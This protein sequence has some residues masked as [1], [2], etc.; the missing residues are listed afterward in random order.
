MLTL[1]VS[2]PL[3]AQIDTTISAPG[4]TSSRNDPGASRLPPA[5]RPEHTASGLPLTHSTDFEDFCG[6]AGIYGC[7]F[8]KPD[9]ES[10][11]LLHAKIAASAELD[12][13][14]Q[15]LAAKASGLDRDLAAL[16]ACSDMNGSSFGASIQAKLDAIK[17]ARQ[18]TEVL[19]A[20]RGKIIA[21]ASHAN[22]L[23]VYNALAAARSDIPKSDL[24]TSA[25]SIDQT[26]GKYYLSERIELEFR[27][28][29]SIEGR[30]KTEGGQYQ[31]DRLLLATDGRIAL[32]LAQRNLDLGL[33][34]Q[35]QTAL[36]LGARLLDVA[37]DFSPMVIA[38]AAPQATLAIGVAMTV[39][40]AKDYYEAR[41]GKRL[42]SGEALAAADRAM[43]MTAVVLD[44]VPLVGPSFR[45][46]A[47]ASDCLEIFTDMM[48]SAKAEGSVSSASAAEVTELSEAV[49]GAERVLESAME[50]GWVPGD[51]KRFAKSAS[52]VTRNGPMNAGRMHDI[53]MGNGTLSYSFRGS[54]YFSYKN[55]D[56]LTL[57]R[58]QGKP[59]ENGYHLG[60]FWTRDKPSGAVQSIIDS[61]LDPTWGNT[62]TYW[63]K[64]EV[65]PGTSLFEGVAASQRGLV[66][67]G[68]QIIVEQIPSTWLKE[69][70]KF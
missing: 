27:R 21:E 18:R 1:L 3:C 29:D 30:I 55:T 10:R 40:F 31:A 9:A 34:E 59:F 64:I 13:K 61:A 11:W 57:Y 28:A 23:A 50:I 43:A 24:A 42:I 44:V 67:G 22:R 58:V 32:D 26:V 14:N 45:A 16:R 51:L 19:Q 46:L 63:V 5:V 70:G 33:L 17:P 38:A 8:M 2:Q 49:Q 4:P 52:D 48:K 54:S 35:S 53:P 60:R 65:P 6:P 25:K 12:L 41:T 20:S 36:R 15:E 56:Q 62:G 37:L 39:A 68:N 7:N 69:Q 47:S 66:G